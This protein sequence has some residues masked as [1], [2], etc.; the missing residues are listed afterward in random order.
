M[1]AFLRLLGW[2]YAKSEKKS[3]PFQAIFSPLGVTLDLTKFREGVLEIQNKSDRIRDLLES[4]D[5]LVL[6]NELY[7][8]N[9]FRFM[10][11]SYSLWHKLVAEQQ[12]LR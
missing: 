9:L 1:Q 11:K 3:L 10:G 8:E 6:R 4:F 7:R 12:F 5:A 2:E